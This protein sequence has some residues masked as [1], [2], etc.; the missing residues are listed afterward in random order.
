MH[1]QPHQKFAAFRAAVATTST[2]PMMARTLARWRGME[3]DRPLHRA[4]VAPK[5]RLLSIGGW[6]GAGCVCGPTFRDMR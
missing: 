1:T 5:W 2:E 3:D 4:G 6:A